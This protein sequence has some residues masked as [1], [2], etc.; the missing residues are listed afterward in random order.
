MPNTYFKIAS[1][2]V[3]SGGASTIDFTSIPSTYTDLCV[4]GSLRG[5][6][7]SWGDNIKVSLNGSTTSF[8]SREIYGESGAT[9]S[10][11]LTTRNV[12]VASGANATASTFGS[13]EFYLPNYLSSNYKSISM[14][15]VSEN[16]ASTGYALWLT[17]GLWSNTAAVT[18]ITFTP[19]SAT[20]WLQYSTATLYGIK[21]S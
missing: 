7:A 18:Q 21:S 15:S 16:N 12:G 3:G 10:E 4:K 20:T 1:V 6:N 8:T 13:F 5:A 2:T 11:T 19:N 9:G 17:A 14:D